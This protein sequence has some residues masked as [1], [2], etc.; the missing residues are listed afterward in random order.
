MLERK[1]A[2]GSGACHAQNCCAHHSSLPAVDCCSLDLAQRHSV[3][4]SHWSY[5]S[6]VLMLDLLAQGHKGYF[7]P[8]CASLIN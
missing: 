6:E 7:Q 2:D 1:Y 3:Q 5:L 8:R 4:A